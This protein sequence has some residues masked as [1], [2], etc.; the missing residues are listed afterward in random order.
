VRE[1]RDI[2][3]DPA[4]GH[5]RQREHTLF[6]DV[7]YGM[8]MDQFQAG[9]ILAV[10]SKSFIGM[11]IRLFSEVDGVACPVNHVAQ[12]IRRKGYLVAAEANFPEFSY[13]RL[14]NYL[15]AQRR[16]KVRLTLLRLNNRLWATNA[17][18]TE[19]IEWMTDY[20]LSLEGR[21]YTWMKLF[22]MAMVSMARNLT[23]LIRGRWQGIP[24]PMTRD[25]TICSATVDFGWYWGQCSTKTDFFPSSLGGVA[26]PADILDSPHTQFIAGWRRE[27][28]I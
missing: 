17:Q 24:V 18:K 25:S 21:S 22:P 14:T 3:G 8:T 11:G 13:T 1:R 15:G 5:H 28:I 4:T 9:D 2:A 7:D 6:V 10:A 26:S 19:A 12:I 27:K 16:G 23:P 20:Q